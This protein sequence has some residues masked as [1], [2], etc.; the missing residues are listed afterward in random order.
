MALNVNREV[1]DD[2]YRYKMPRLIAKVEG[3]GNGI[4]TVIVNMPEVAKA[5][6][7]PPIY[8]TKFFGA[9]LG[10]QI[11]F[12][13]KNER[14]IVNGAHDC[15]KL[16][17]IL[18]AFIRKYV[19]CSKC[20]NP[21][22]DL[23]V[24]TRGKQGG[25]LLAK[26][27]ACGCLAPVPDNGRT[28]QF[29]LKNP[30]DETGLALAAGASSGKGGRGAAG[31]RRRRGGAN[32]GTTAD[33]SPEGGNSGEESN[34]HPDDGD[35]DDLNGAGVGGD[36]FD[37][38]GEWEG[39]D[40]ENDRE[41]QRAA[42]DELP[43][44][45]QRLIVTDEMLELTPQDRADRFHKFLTECLS[46][47]QLSPGELVLE[48][49][50]LDIRD[51]AV[52]VV[53]E[54]LLDSPATLVSDIAKTYRPV[55]LAFVGGDKNRRAQKYLMGAVET[56]IARFRDSLLDAKRIPNLLNAFYSA[57]LLSEETLI[58]WAAK[59]PSK[60]YSGDRK[61]SRSIHELS[62]PFINWLQTA[63]EESSSEDDGEDEE[64]NKEAGHLKE[65]INGNGSTKS[66][67]QVRPSNGGRVEEEQ[68]DSDVDIDN[69]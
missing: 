7:R 55:F 25:E 43:A 46:S 39:G 37:S 6:G 36:D 52:L 29:I 8:P 67:R 65:K 9:E 27:K 40:D 10:A 32:G 22:T 11:Q 14:F 66:S 5:L 69:I 15:D 51:K 1:S 49:E 62:Q 26:C 60:R 61:L 54:V 19:L 28:A 59:G 38:D 56:L 3:K 4:K 50:R 68:P 44:S 33:R 12:D 17:T 18:D 47:G 41:Q 58:E 16:Q 31:T 35:A 42:A 63:D 13:Q 24:R 20:E 2:F 30:P 53:V 64:N 48:A 34:H 23:I 45:I 21:E 57:D